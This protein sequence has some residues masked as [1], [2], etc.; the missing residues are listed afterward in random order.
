TGTHTGETH[1]RAS[2]AQLVE[3]VCAL[4][5]HGKL[6]RDIKPSNVL[7]SHQGRVVLLDFGL[8]RDRAQRDL[9]GVR[10]EPLVVGPPEYMPPEQSIGEQATPASDWYSVGVMLFESLTGALPFE[11]T[12]AQ[13]ISARLLDEAPPPSRFARE[14]PADLEAL[15]VGLLRRDPAE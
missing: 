4:H 3:G 14:V 15:C 8:V 11:G 9:A 13:I 12:A 5:A 7:V 1:L 2:L 10:D 6:H